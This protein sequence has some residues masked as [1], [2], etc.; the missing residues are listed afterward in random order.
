MN[1]TQYATTGR[2][3]AHSE[4]IV[5]FLSART[6]NAALL[7]VQLFLGLYST[8]GT[9]P[10]KVRVVDSSGPGDPYYIFMVMKHLDRVPYEDYRLVRRRYLETYMQVLKVIYPNAKDIVGIATG[11]LDNENSEDLLYLDVRYWTVKDQQQAEILQRETGFLTQIKRF[12]GKVKTYPD[13]E[14]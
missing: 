10:W 13:V 1:D 9:Q 7:L 5:R 8:L 12:G 3:V 14:A 6:Q 4:R 2:G 11:P